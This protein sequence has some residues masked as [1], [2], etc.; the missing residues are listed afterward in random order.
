MVLSVD[1]VHNSTLKVAQPIDMNHVGAARTLNTTAATNAIKATLVACGAATIQASLAPG[2][3]PGGSGL[4]KTATIVDYAN[5]GL[6]SGNVVLG[7]GSPYTVGETPATGAAFPGVNPAFGNMDIIMPT[8]R[9]GYDALQVVFKEQKTHPL[10]GVMSSNLQVAYSLSRIVSTVPLGNGGVGDQF[11]ITQNGVYNND[12]TTANMGRSSLDHTHQ[13]S[14]GG[15]MTASSTGRRSPSLGTSS[16]RH[17]QT[18]RLTRRG[19]AAVQR[20]ASSRATSTAMVCSA[21]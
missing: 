1:Y 8:G 21:I 12:N 7:G 6:D 2:G 5:N 11:F 16:R 15:S 13:I 10:P 4:N 18:L 20:R 17:R 14:F 9:S 3:C 19:R